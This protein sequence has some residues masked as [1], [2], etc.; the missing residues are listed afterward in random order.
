MRLKTARF[1]PLEDHEFT[2]AHRA[3]LAPT[4]KAGFPLYNI[5]RTMVRAPDAREAFSH[6]SGYVLSNRNTLPAREREIVILRCGYLCRAG[7]EFM[8]HKQ[9][10]LKAGLTA[11]EVENIKKGADAGWSPADA[12]LIRAADGM[13]K[14]QFVSERAWQELAQH[15]TERQ[16]M[17][18][19][20][21]GAQYIQISI[22]LNSFGVQLEEGWDLDP[23]LDAT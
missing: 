20:F 3:A 16:I 11:Q 2:D 23:E 14:D 1:A 13:A 10:G 4:I 5:L 17:D 12:A 21:S 7:Y 22:M 18:V 6:W 15:F 19:V 8:H 9:I